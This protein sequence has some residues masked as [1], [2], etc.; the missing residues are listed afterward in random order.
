M[1]FILPLWQISSIIMAWTAASLNTKRVSFS[2]VCDDWLSWVNNKI[3]MWDKQAAEVK[4]KKGG[5][6]ANMGT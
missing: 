2:Q 1:N 5:S 6:L 3:Q 4:K